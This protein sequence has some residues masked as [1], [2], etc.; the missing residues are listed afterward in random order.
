M[1]LYLMRHG[2]TDYNKARCFYG[3]HDVSIN[4]EGQEQARVLAQVL[5][6][7]KVDIIYTSRLKRTQETARL[8]FPNR[9]FEALPYFDEKGFGAW[10]GLTADEIE[11]RFPDIWQA[12]LEAPFEVTPPQAEVFSAFQE[13]V[14]QGLDALVQL[15]SDKAVAIVAHL[16]VLRL[17]YQRL[18]KDGTS[19]WDIDFPQGTVTCLERHTLSTW[20]AYPLPKEGGTNDC[21]T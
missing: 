4:Q 14:W 10:E 5:E 8:V 16:G 15:H 21:N 17:I 7:V 6:G 20:V 1:K 19:F 18:I 11:E 13:R 12:W 9:P 3:S 2:Q